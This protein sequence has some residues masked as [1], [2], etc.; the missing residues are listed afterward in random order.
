MKEENKKILV[1]LAIS[2]CLIAIAVIVYD[3]W[4]QKPE[5]RDPYHLAG[6]VS[7]SNGSPI[8]GMNITVSNEAGILV[9]GISDEKGEFELEI[10]ACV[11]KTE[12]ATLGKEMIN[13]GPVISHSAIEVKRFWLCGDPWV[14][15]VKM[16]KNGYSF[17]D[18]TTISKGGEQHISLIS[19]YSG[20]G[21]EK[22]IFD[23]NYEIGQAE[24]WLNSA[25]GEPALFKIDFIR[26]HI[27]GANISLEDIGT[28]NQ[29][30]VV[31]VRAAHLHS[32]TFWLASA[33]EEP[34]L[35]KIN[36]IMEHAVSGRLPLE[37]IGTSPE[38]LKAL[39]EKSKI[40]EREKDVNVYVLFP[41]FSKSVIL[42]LSR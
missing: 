33:R 36:F 4:Q 22:S 15:S 10:P 12:Y 23:R 11:L 6:N 2:L 8:A 37:K 20:S 18:E 25:R 21:S 3:D 17:T 31:L 14:V 39:R 41:S 9:T 5:N 19:S 30:I 34:K 29:E 28:S 27:R 13:E 42:G 1:S 24:Y 32:A 38:E 7:E 40:S 16:E 26:D 35:Y